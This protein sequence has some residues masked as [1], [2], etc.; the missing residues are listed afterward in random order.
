MF[1]HI[2]IYKWKSSVTPEEVKKALAE[3]KALETKIP[4]ITEISWGKNT[5][6]YGEGYSHVILIR[7]DDETAI[8]G[9]RQHPDHQKVAE[10][11]EAMEDHGIGVDF[12]PN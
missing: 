4:G 8:N 3:V 2:A 9:Y 6:K 10:K 12:T 1:V 11:I 5:S 7:A